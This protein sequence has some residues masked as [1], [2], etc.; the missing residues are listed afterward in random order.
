MD[1]HKDRETTNMHISEARTPYQSDIEPNLPAPLERIA[2]AEN[3][4]QDLVEMC[5]SVAQL[6]ILQTKILMAMAENYLSSNNYTDQQ[7]AEN[8]GIH[9]NTINHF[10]RNPSA[11][12]AMT[13][14]I[15][16]L[17][18]SKI[19][20]YISGIEKAGENDWRA[21]ELMLK[22]LGVYIPKQQSLNINTRLDSPGQAGSLADVIDDFLIKLG[23]AGYPIEKLVERYQQLRAEGAF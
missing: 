7:I 2:S 4:S 16:G 22:V 19:D 9:P 5:A 6:T 14:V 17:A 18:G 10:R 23:A 20:K 11:A 12:K 1:L 15:L 3:Q 8:L 21:Y 13:A